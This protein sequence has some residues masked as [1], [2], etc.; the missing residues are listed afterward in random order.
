MKKRL[1]LLL[2]SLLLTGLSG[3]DAQTI[4]A[5][6]G[7]LKSQQGAGNTSGSPS[8][9][10]STPA[11]SSPAPTFPGPTPLPAPTTGPVSTPTP[12]SSA[13]PELPA[14]ASPSGV[15]LPGLHS[16]NAKEQALAE[17][18]NRYRQA[19]GL[20]ALPVSPHLSRVARLHSED[21]QKHR[22]HEIPQ[23]GKTCN[24]HSWSANGPWSPCCYT[25]DHAQSQCMWDKPRELTPHTG[26]GFE[27]SA[28]SFGRDMSAD[29]LLEIWKGSQGHNDVIL[30]KGIWQDQP[31]AVMGVGIDEGERIYANVWFSHSPDP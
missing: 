22:T 20:P 2:S 19:N 23:N 9:Q 5:I 27:I 6:L 30:N 1:Q 26:D 24:L 25:S 15:S 12:L 29:D 31:F 7:E 3:C 13:T 28:Y 14:S 8:A 18:I 17:A 16:L 4:T 11:S 10:P 21:L